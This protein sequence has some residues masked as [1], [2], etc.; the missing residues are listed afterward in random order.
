MF[1]WCQAVCFFPL[2]YLVQ[3]VSEAYYERLF[4]R[5]R[6][7]ERER[8]LY[9]FRHMHLCRRQGNLCPR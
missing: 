8:E 4:Q 2:H 3:S 1:P 9:C 5:Y 7:G 6:D